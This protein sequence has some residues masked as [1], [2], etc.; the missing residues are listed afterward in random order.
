[1]LFI[2]LWFP[3]KI[4]LSFLD[5]INKYPGKSFHFLFELKVKLEID[6]SCSRKLDFG[7]WS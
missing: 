1:L 7:N 5:D 3:L 2:S 4:F 6:F